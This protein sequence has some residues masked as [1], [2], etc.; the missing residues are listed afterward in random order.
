MIEK[1]AL[2]RILQEF[3]CRLVGNH[4]LLDNKKA[5]HHR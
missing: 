4:T 1:I 2:K 3:L 5:P